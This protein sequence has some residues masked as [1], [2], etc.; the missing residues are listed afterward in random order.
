MIDR[1]TSR[2]SLMKGVV[3]SAALAVT[4][5]GGGGLAGLTR[6]D[7]A[8]AKRRVAVL[9][10]GIA[11]LTAA[12]E[13]VERGFEVTVY[14]RRAWGGKAR[15]IETPSV[16]AGGRKP[17]P[18][19]HGFR[20]FPGFYQAIPDTMRRIPF[21]GNA[22]GV[23]DNLVPA[24]TLTAAWDGPDI[25]T[26]AALD[27]DAMGLTL[28]PERA[29]RSMLGGLAWVPRMPTERALG[30]GRRLLVYFTSCDER[31]F[32]QWEYTSFKDFARMDG[33]DINYELLVST[34]T[35]TLVAAKEHVASARTI[36]NMAEAFL[37]NVINRGNDN[38]YPDMV[39]NGPT[40][41]V[42]IE[43]WVAYLRSRG[44]RFELGA[45]VRSL[46][47]RDRLIAGAEV[48]DRTGG[49]ATVEADW[50]V[51][52]F[53]PDQVPKYLSP[54]ILRLDPALERIR[55]LR[56]DWMNGIQFFL[57]TD[58][59]IG[60]GHIGFI[61]SPWRLTA[62]NQNQFWRRKVEA[63][64]G[65][66]TVKD[67]L[68]LCISDWDAPGVLTRKP[69]RE[70]NPD[71]VAREVWYQVTRSQE[72]ELLFPDRLTDDDLHSWFLDPAIRWDPAAGVNTNADPL[73]INTV[74]SWDNRPTSTTAIP[75]LFLAGDY[76]RNN[77]DLAT[78]EGACEG[79]RT[80]ANAVL[81]A[82]GSDAERAKLVPRSTIGEFDAAREIDRQR[83]LAGL[84]NL[85]DTAL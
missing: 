61:E 8:P 36:C 18:G 22:N 43:P 40:S 72:G 28:H 52:A 59:P 51:L 2:R 48:A 45:E 60:P 1:T 75:N 4:M 62:I 55:E 26:P 81:D 11:G 68:S 56:V 6:A 80:A 20:F 76:V 64:Y 13:L 3:G 25:T 14:E 10:G 17:L 34:L 47:V 32:G 53:P 27:F 73:L 69:A 66:G 29:I 9:G 74:G 35:R 50:F 12:H 84:P 31:R 44:V 83:W 78:M 42:W 39:L 49:T 67:V 7:A 24:L 65:D 82:A 15:S 58:E 37:L 16:V 41:E 79:G 85:L 46:T 30:L 23:Y 21:P 63:S 70:C 54:E 71:E 5:A 77:I 57:K 19:E 33:T 38:R